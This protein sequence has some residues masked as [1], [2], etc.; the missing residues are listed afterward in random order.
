MR[1]KVSRRYLPVNSRITA[2]TSTS[3][4]IRDMSSLAPAPSPDSNLSIPP[5]PVSSATTS[6]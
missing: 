6:R 5:L 1:S 3:N 2:A 4:P